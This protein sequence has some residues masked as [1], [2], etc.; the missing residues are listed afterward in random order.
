LFTPDPEVIDLV[1]NVLPI[2]AVMQLFDGMA[3]VSHGLLRGIGRQEFGG[4]ANL[5]IYYIVAVPIS[6]GLAFGLG[7]ELKG[8]WL[9]VTIGLCL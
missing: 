2:V 9:G 7:W 5:A 4:Y 8:L 1:A 3:A 6:F